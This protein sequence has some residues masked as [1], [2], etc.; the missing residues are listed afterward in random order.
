[1]LLG[2]TNNPRKNPV[3]EVKRI[4][5]LGFEFVDLTCEPPAATAAQ[6]TEA[7]AELHAALSSSSLKVVG[8]TSW[9][10][11]FANPYESVRK[12]HLG[13]CIAAID[14]LAGLGAKK[15]GIHPDPMAKFYFDRAAYLLSYSRACSELSAACKERGATLLIETFS[16]EYL[17]GEEL[18]KVF[19]AVPDA[20][21]TLDVGHANTIAL[22]GEGIGRLIS[23]FKGKLTHVHVSDNDGKSDLHLPIGAGKI[24]WKKT[25]S[26]LKSGGYNGT[27]TLEVFSQDADYVKLSAE[28][29]RKLW[30]CA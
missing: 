28:K 11:E 30:D 18:G 10:H 1:M 21:F 12:A 23:Q 25:L 5:E 8:H 7:A 6:L 29:F 27:V 16:E 3:D 15:I 13:E 4:G 19:L 17:T 20:R 14:V 24:D 26:L 9:L 22:N 2:S